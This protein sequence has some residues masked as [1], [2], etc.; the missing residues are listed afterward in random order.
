MSAKMFEN[1]RLI[2]ALIKMIHRVYKEIIFNNC[3]KGC[4]GFFL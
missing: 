1:N 2:T 4:D 3:E